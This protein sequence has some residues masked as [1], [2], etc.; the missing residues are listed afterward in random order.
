MSPG[1]PRLRFPVYLGIPEYTGCIPGACRE[2]SGAAVYL[3]IPGTPATFPGI[4]RCFASPAQ[5][6]EAAP[7][8]SGY[9]PSPGGI[10]GN[11]SVEDRLSQP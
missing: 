1:M 3:G 4:P 2:T 8:V 7:H 10:P 6:L 11:G 9:T 5:S